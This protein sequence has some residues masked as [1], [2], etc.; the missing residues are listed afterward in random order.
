MIATSDPL[1]KLYLSSARADSPNNILAKIY[2]KLIS[3]QYQFAG[4]QIRMLGGDLAHPVKEPFAF[5]IA[6]FECPRM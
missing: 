3:F 1:R 5:R 4:S 6:W 2:S